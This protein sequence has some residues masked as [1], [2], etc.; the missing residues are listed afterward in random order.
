MDHA[1]HWSQ[2]AFDF[3]VAHTGKSASIFKVKIEEANYENISESLDT[4]FLFGRI[5]I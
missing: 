4:M 2:G 5:R 3:V 1:G